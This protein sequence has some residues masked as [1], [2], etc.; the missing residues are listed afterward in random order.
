MLISGTAGDTHHT[1]TQRLHGGASSV[2]P[3]PWSLLRGA[4]SSPADPDRLRLRAAGEAPCLRTTSRPSPGVDASA[5][6]SYLQVGEQ[7]LSPRGTPRPEA[8]E[9]GEEPPEAKTNAPCFCFLLKTK[10]KQR[11]AW[12]RRSAD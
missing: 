1:K 12:T 7:Q 8:A 9:D 10:I 2:E 11:A 4:S 5:W 3:P 6:S